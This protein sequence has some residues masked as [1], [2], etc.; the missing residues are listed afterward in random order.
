MLQSLL[1]PGVK[2]AFQ[3]AAERNRLRLHN[4]VAHALNAIWRQQ[5]Q[6]PVLG[7]AF[8]YILLI[9]VIR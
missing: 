8:T 4:T 5:R 2:V 3:E 9:P 6:P 1:G 7:M